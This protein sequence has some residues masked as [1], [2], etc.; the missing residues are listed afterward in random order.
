MRR[1]NPSLPR[2]AASH[3][4][5]PAVAV[6]ELWLFAS[7]MKT[8]F[9]S[10][11]LLFACAFQA[12]AEAGASLIVAT[13]NVNCGN[14]HMDQI[15]DAIKASK[16]DVIFLQET[17]V[18]SERYLKSELKSLYPYF[19]STGYERRFAEDRLAF[20]SKLPLREIVFSPPS[21]GHFGCYSAICEI[22]KTTVKLINIHLAS[23]AIPPQAGVI[24]ILTAMNDAE[25]SHA[26]EIEAISRMIA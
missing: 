19:C 11:S 4:E 12:I 13:F 26:V 5:R 10:L 25:G 1:H 2:T 14:L 7:V 24:G 16:A 21:G 15:R 8:L 6:A 23:F 9:I 18:E 22:G 20:L 17:T 3:S